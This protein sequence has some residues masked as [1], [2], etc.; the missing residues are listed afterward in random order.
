MR[1]KST[2][3]F[4]IL[5]LVL[6][7][8]VALLCTAAVYQ[9]FLPHSDWL[10]P[11]NSDDAI[12][13]IMSRDGFESPFSL[14][15][16]GQNR[17]G[18]WAYMLGG[19]MAKVMGHVPTAVDIFQASF[20]GFL[21]GVILLFRVTGAWLPVALTIFFAAILAGR[22]QT[23]VLALM[24]MAQ[25]YLMFVGGFCLITTVVTSNSETS[26]GEEY[27]SQRPVKLYG[28]LDGSRRYLVL[29]FSLF[30]LLIWLNRA[31][32]PV[33]VGVLVF[34]Y[35]TKSHI[36]EP[37]TVIMSLIA[38]SLSEF[39][40]RRFH[41][42]YSLA[43]FQKGFRYEPGLDLKNIFINTVKITNAFATT[44]VILMALVV[45][46]WLML[47]GRRLFVRLKRGY[48]QG[49]EISP[50]GKT[51]AV[52]YGLC[53]AFLAQFGLIS[54]TNWVRQNSYHQRYLAV[55]YCFLA[56]IFSLVIV[57]LLQRVFR[58][59]NSYQRLIAAFGVYAG[60]GYLAL[61]NF[62]VPH[63]N[64][65]DLEQIAEARALSAEFPGKPLLGQYWG[66]YLYPALQD[67]NPVIPILTEG[68][69][70]RMPWNKEALSQ[71]T[72]ILVSHLG[73]DKFG[74]ADQ[75]VPE[76]QEYG[77]VYSLVKPRALRD[78][79]HP[80]DAP[81]SLYRVKQRSLKR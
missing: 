22:D 46:G 75:P 27:K 8:S 19:W 6:V 3:W 7:W 38:A 59:Y 80:S 11:F 68:D 74:S 33:M 45:M 34:L 15:Y 76:F 42:S 28:L 9:G 30:F 69:Y 56:L 70:D 61:H 79:K 4:K 44:E 5:R 50:L 77:R 60:I 23:Q 62:Q 39:L 16:Y 17:L 52:I 31:T 1:P 63:Q 78:S 58:R 72:E 18:S 29:T 48:S 35:L 32:W 73:G 10:P 64:Q 54:V 66:V 43:T 57:D 26:L 55:S 14:Y 49:S 65:K 24:N 71:S 36:R 21:A 13:V 41:Y 67:E 40:L 37:R 51:P 53:G 20:A 2:L 47:D 81:I 12:A 25:P